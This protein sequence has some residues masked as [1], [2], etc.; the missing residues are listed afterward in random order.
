VEKYTELSDVYLVAAI[1]LF[2]D[3]QPILK[4]HNRHTLFCF[5]ASDALYRAMNDYNNGAVLNAMEYA[6][7]IK[8]FRAEM[9]MRRKMEAGQ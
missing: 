2:L 9:M 6:Q 5:P 4:V 8:R 1:T 7:A 3:I